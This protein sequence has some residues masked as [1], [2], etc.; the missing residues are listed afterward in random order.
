NG[1][2]TTSLLAGSYKV[3]ASAPNFQPS[4]AVQVT[5]AENQTTT[6]NIAL[7]PLVK[8]T[9][10]VAHLNTW[11]TVTDGVFVEWSEPFEQSMAPAVTNGYRIHAQSDCNDASIA[12]A[13]RN[14]WLPER[15][16]STAPLITGTGSGP[17]RVRDMEFNGMQNVVPGNTYYLEV[18]ANTEYGNTSKQRNDR[19][20]VPLTSN[21]R[22]LDRSTVAGTVTSAGNQPVAGATVT[23]TRTIGQPGTVAATG[24]TD[25][26]GNY[27][28]PNVQIS[29][30]ANT[31][32][33]SNLPQGSY[34]NSPYTLTVTAAGKVTK[35]TTAAATG[36]GTTTTVNV[37]LKS[38]PVA[39]NDSY[40]TPE[41]TPLTVNAPGVLANDTDADGDPLTAAVATGPAHG[42]LTLNADGSFTYTPNANYNG[43]DSFTYTVTDGSG[44]ATATVNIAVGAVNDPP[45]AA[46]DAYSTNED[47][48]LSVSAPGVLGN[49]TDA[50]GDTLTAA[51]ATGPA[52]GTLTLN[53]NGSFTYTPAANYN[54]PDSFTYTAS[55]GN[56]GSATATVAITVNAVNDAP[57][58]V[59]DSYTATKNVA[60][61][62]AAPGVLGNDTDVEA[63]A[64][65]AAV[66]TGPAKGTLTLNTNG[67]FSYTPNVGFVGTDSFT[68]KATDGAGASSA[69]ATATITVVAPTSASADL[70]VAT[71]DSPD[72]AAKGGTVTYTVTVANAG[73]SPATSV[74]LTA[75]IKNGTLLTLTS[76]QGT[77][78]TRTKTCSLD[79]I[80][81]GGSV[82]VTVT[83]KAPSKAG[84]MSLTAKASSPVADPNTANNTKTESTTIT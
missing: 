3:S 69:P 56:G 53:A 58:A 10:V 73:P 82:T 84:T 34:Y 8:P 59:A 32:N 19:V 45:V 83:A 77:C 11:K 9:V 63:G 72:P 38:D 14:N 39:A 47:T 46:N 62:V 60:L 35:T 23:L 30:F 42:T 66:A 54:G 22:T 33:P 74:T 18:G 65:T 2:Y 5:V 57:T 51:V 1:D 31:A 71:A 52:H 75:A 49:D 43:P 70:S 20:C 13:F 48:A 15:Q 7:G 40:S 64:L 26:S 16:N 4:T 78:S 29:L 6:Q 79:T 24:T 44:S 37:A 28:I 81:A 25:A 12:T 41:D 76:S 27:S 21:I 80:A 67:S 50:D 55:D 36:N 17:S 61:S 68:Y